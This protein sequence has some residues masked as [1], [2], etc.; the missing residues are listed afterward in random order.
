MLEVDHFSQN[1]YLE[2]SER[3]LSRVKSCMEFVSHN[4][5]NG[6]SQKGK[7]LADLKFLEKLKIRNDLY[8]ETPHPLSQ[9]IMEQTG[10]TRKK[11]EEFLR[12]ML[13]EAAIESGTKKG[14][15]WSPKIIYEE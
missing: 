7:R 8:A 12:N 10:K 1:T 4:D 3:N 5:C 11:R 13:K 2:G 6:S 9:Y 15:Y 14:D